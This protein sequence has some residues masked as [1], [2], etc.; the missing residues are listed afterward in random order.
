MNLIDIA[1]KKPGEGY[2]TADLIK[3]LAVHSL[4]NEMPE[5]EIEK[6]PFSLVI[7]F[8]ITDCHYAHT[9]EQGNLFNDRIIGIEAQTQALANK[10]QEK[11]KNNPKTQA[12]AKQT[13]D[14]LE[15]SLK[16]IKE[17]QEKIRTLYRDLKTGVTRWQDETQSI[18]NKIVVSPSPEETHRSHHIKTSIEKIFTEVQKSLEH[19]NTLCNT[20]EIVVKHALQ[21]NEHA[22]TAHPDLASVL[23]KVDLSKSTTLAQETPIPGASQVR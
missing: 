1:R 21:T 11:V 19:F 23:Q 20:A 18:T 2:D 17:E 7:E 15:I 10:L 12:D 16:H 22:V 13:L 8:A 3:N 9:I 6:I 14:S 4:G 5:N